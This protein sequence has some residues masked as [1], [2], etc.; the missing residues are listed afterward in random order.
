MSQESIEYLYWYR[1]GVLHHV[2]GKAE[3]VYA[4]VKYHK[5]EPYYCYG[6]GYQF[7]S[8]WYVLNNEYGV[9]DIVHESSVPA[10]IRALHLIVYRGDYE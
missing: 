6:A 5:A 1:N 7:H 3:V 9:K 4:N 8:P 10:Q 2:I